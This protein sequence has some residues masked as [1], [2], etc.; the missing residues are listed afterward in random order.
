MQE[1]RSFLAYRKIVERWSSVFGKDKI[2]ERLF[3]KQAFYENDLLADFAHVAGFDMTGLEKAKTAGLTL[4]ERRHQLNEISPAYYGIIT[5]GHMVITNESLIEENTD[6][7]QRFMS[8]IVEAT[9][10]YYS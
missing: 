4:R 2:K 7:V 8:S 10:Y 6:L 1:E 9:A 3:D 5:Q